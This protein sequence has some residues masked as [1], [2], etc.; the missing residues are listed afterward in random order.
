MILRKTRLLDSFGPQTRETLLVPAFPDPARGLA[1]GYYLPL[2]CKLVQMRR[3]QAQATVTAF[4]SVA[5]GAGV[6]H[7][8]ESLA[9]ELAKH[10]GKQILLTS[11]DG[12]ASPP[13][14]LLWAEEKPI[15]SRGHRLVEVH[16]SGQR[17][18]HDLRWQ[19]L[20]GMRE[21]FGFVLVDCPAMNE[22]PV[23]LNVARMADAVVLVVAAE[24]TN[25]DQVQAAQRTLLAASANVLGAVLN[26]RRNPIPRVISRY[27]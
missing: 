25:P 21:R 22:S 23:I 16:A 20:R 17:I 13:A 12:L 6:T 4:T 18:V 2:V 27:L 19:D 8:T 26:K 7:V 11:G 1:N 24:E 3:D 15:R 10:T 9:W 5:S 14:H